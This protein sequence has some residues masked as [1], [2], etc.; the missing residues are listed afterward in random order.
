M[1]M[2]CGEVLE[3]IYLIL[4]GELSQEDCAELQVHLER[5]SVCYGR[6]ETERLFKELVRQR[7]GCEP[8]PAALVSR[9]KVALEVETF[10][11]EA[12]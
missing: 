11:I 9:I 12:E 8:A 7:C 10:S 6:H 4:D 5:C 1:S 2:D 3:R